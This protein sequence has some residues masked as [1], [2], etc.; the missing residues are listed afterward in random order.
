M[1]DRHTRDVSEVSW[2]RVGSCGPDGR[3]T[4]VAEDLTS[5]SPGGAERPDARTR[6]T[7]PGVTGEA[8]ESYRVGHDEPDIE[9]WSE[10]DARQVDHGE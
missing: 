10:L 9:W 6:G 4:M 5:G 8:G 1:S 3:A 7:V 2:R